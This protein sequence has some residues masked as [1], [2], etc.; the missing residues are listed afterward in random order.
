M[1]SKSLLP[2]GNYPNTP[3]FV[4]E[5]QWRCEAPAALLEKGQAHGTSLAVGNCRSYGDSCLAYSSHA[6]KMTSLNRFLSADW[7]TGLITVEAGITLRE[8][9]EVCVPQGW[10]LPVTPGTQF[11]TVGGAIANDVHGK[12]HHVRGTFG[13]HVQALSL[14]R[15]E[16]GESI[17]SKDENSELFAATIGGLGLTGIITWATIQLIRINSTRIDTTTIRY[18]T[19]TDFF[20]ISEELDA[21][22]EYG[23]AWI[24]CVAKGS[25]LGRGVYFTGNHS[26]YGDLRINKSNERNV[27]FTPPISLINRQSLVAFNTLYWHKHSAATKTVK[28]FY[29]PFFYPLDSIKNWNRIYGPKGFQQYQCVIPKYHAQDAMNEILRTISISEQGSFLAVLKRCGDIKSPGLLSFPM[30]GT[31]LALDFSNQSAPQQELFLRL[32]EIV[33]EAGGRLYPAKDAHMSGTHF[34]NAYP[35]WETLMKLRDPMLNSKFWQR[36]TT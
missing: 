15:S 29:E 13:R 25:K 18:D 17:H 1:M 27:P 2:W 5:I 30:E 28:Q 34:R 10:F 20:A 3:Q 6:L 11:V 16:Q 33:H 36:V 24:D 4:D 14:V 26:K 8:I 23:V 7:T 9:L 12:N 22:N 35:N 19:L 31:S 32:D 21:V